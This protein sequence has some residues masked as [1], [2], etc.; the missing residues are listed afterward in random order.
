MCLT[1]VCSN[2]NAESRQGRQYHDSYSHCS[3]GVPTEL[4]LLSILGAFG[5]AYAILYT[6]STMN[7]GRKK[8][9][10]SWTSQLLDLAWT[11]KQMT[12][13]KNS[14]TGRHCSMT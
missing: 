13:K 6:A 1:K 3:A 14:P 12:R 8:R 2:N 7:T 10:L 9:Q 4:A 11:G 5:A